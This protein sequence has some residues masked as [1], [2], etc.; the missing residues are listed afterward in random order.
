MNPKNSLSEISNKILDSL[1]KGKRNIKT[2]IDEIDIQYVSNKIAIERN[3]EI[4][5]QFL[6]YV[7]IGNIRISSEL[8]SRLNIQFIR[9]NILMEKHT[10]KIV[11]FIVNTSRI[12]FE[13][14]ESLVDLLL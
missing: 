10:I 6:R 1:R 12:E 9:E 4:I 7:S 8:L 5:G 13:F 11:K 3:L 14:Y 2:I